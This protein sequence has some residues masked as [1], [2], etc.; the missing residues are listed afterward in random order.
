VPEL[1]GFSGRRG[2]DLSADAILIVLGVVVLVG[3]ALLAFSTLNRLGFGPD[4][5]DPELDSSED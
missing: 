4:R 2:N 1:H 3:T 5:H